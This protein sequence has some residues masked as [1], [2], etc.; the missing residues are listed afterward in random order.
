MVTD[1]ATTSL[2]HIKELSRS[3]TEKLWIRITY[4]MLPLDIGPRMGISKNRVVVR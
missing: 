3:S 2:L 1:T 4:H